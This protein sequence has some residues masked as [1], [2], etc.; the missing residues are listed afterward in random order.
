MDFIYL[1]FYGCLRLRFLD[2]ETNPGPR[3]PVPGVCRILRRMCYAWPGTLVSWPRLRLSMI[4]C[5]ALRL[6]SQICTTCRRCWFPF[7]VAL[8]CCVGARCLG[9]VG[10]LHTFEMVTEHFANP[11]CTAYSRCE[12]TR[13]LWS[14]SIISLFLYLKSPAMNPSSLLA[15][16]QLFSVCCCHL[17]SLVI[18]IPRSLCCS[19]TGKLLVGHGVVAIYIVVSN[20]HHC[21]F[22]NIQFHLPLVGQIFE[23]VDVF[24]KLYYVVWVLCFVALHG[25]ISEFGYC[26][27]DV[28]IQVID[29]VVAVVGV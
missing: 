7:S 14:G 17:R 27:D 12:R 26:T 2:V 20:V 8:S 3:R 15:V 23:L 13:D 22:V 18:M 11:N 9:P 25:V 24:L 4:Y 29:V 19:V 10:W 5:C 28:V 21:A 16:L 1:I 6:W